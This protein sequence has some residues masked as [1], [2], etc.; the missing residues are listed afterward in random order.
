MYTSQT[1]KLNCYTLSF[2]VF[3][4]INFE[5]DKI[6]YQAGGL[7]ID[8][9]TG[10]SQKKKIRI[11]EVDF[12]CSGWPHSTGM[13][14]CTGLCSLHLSLPLLAIWAAAFPVNPLIHGQCLWTAGG[15]WGVRGVPEGDHRRAAYGMTSLNPDMPTPRSPQRRSPCVEM[16]VRVG[17][18]P[19]VIV[20][21]KV[22][23]AHL[24]EGRKF[25]QLF[26]SGHMPLPSYFER[27]N[28]HFR[29]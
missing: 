23:P 26:L 15:S 1:V 3:P 25:L 27:A 9:A 8:T 13:P 29:S 4:L 17:G 20:C 24:K 21:L 19:D 12:P 18:D 5:T 10:C 14:W 28:I 7:M 22:Q 6:I 16:L 2:Q 11:P